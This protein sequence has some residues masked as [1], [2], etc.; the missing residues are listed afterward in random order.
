MDL[1]TLRQKFVEISGRYDLVV[2]TTAWADN[3]ADFYIQ[4]G[5]DYLD[6]LETMKA[7]VSRIFE[8]IAADEWYVIFERCRAVQEVWCSDSDFERW[9]LTKIDFDILRAAYNELP[10]NLDTGD[11]LYYAP[12]ALRKTPETVDELTVDYFYTTETTES[13][14]NWTYNGIMFMPPADAA[15]TIEIK[16]LFLHP[17]LSADGDENFWSSVYPQALI[18]AAC[19]SVEI[20]YRNTEGVKDWERSIAIE[21]RGLGMDSVEEDIASYDQMEG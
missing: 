12:L 18:M 10:A 4:S 5:Q 9:E 2:N 6:R 11:P 20:M 17:K 14:D 3:G 16:G 1:V 7:S 21:L 13:Y 15:F 8:T 19:R